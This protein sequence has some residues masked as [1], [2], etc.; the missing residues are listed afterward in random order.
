MSNMDTKQ[1]AMDTSANILIEK[2]KSVLYGPLRGY[3]GVCLGG[4]EII[5]TLFNEFD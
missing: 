2:S 5:V 3:G 4:A 1:T